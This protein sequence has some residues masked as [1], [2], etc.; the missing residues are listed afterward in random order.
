MFLQYISKL[1]RERR[2][3]ALLEWAYLAISVVSFMVAGILALFSQPLGVGVLIIPF[4]SFIAFSMNVVAWALIKL[5][6][7]NLIPAIEEAK[8][9]TKKSS[10]KST[11]AARS[12]KAQK[13]ST[14][15]TKSAKTKKST[16]KNS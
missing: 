5:A 1:Y 10:T 9:A 16:A 7:D 4:V 11:Q 6:V 3:L 14:K 8:P 2:E 13:T 15:S 12:T